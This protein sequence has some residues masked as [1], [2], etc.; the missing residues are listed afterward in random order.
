M[1]STEEKVKCQAAVGQV[2]KVGEEAARLVGIVMTIVPA[3]DGE[4]GDESIEGEESADE[5]EHEWWEEPG[6]CEARC[7]VEG[8]VNAQEG[9]DA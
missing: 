3:K 8:V 6:G 1:Q 4:D 9:V 2:S 7:W 5:G